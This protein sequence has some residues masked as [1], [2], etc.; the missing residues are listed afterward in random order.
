MDGVKPNPVLAISLTAILGGNISSLLS[1][2]GFDEMDRVESPLEQFYDSAE[3]YV[4]VSAR[5]RSL[6]Q[7]V[8]GYENGESARVLS[9][10]TSA[11][12]HAHAQPKCNCLQQ[13][14]DKVLTRV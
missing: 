13:T 1:G 4:G 14:N 8:I 12:A 10:P 7:V 3:C 5:K 2:E 9:G 6:P 11:H